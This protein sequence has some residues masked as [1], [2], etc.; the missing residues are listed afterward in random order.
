[1]ES[2]KSSMPA[3]DYGTLLKEYEEFAYVISHDLSGPLRQIAGFT[4]ILLK[5][6]GELPEKQKIYRDMIDHAVREAQLS[7]DALLEFSRLNTDEKNFE[8]FGYQRIICRHPEKAASGDCRQRRRY[9]IKRPA[10]NPARRQKNTDT[11][12]LPP[13]A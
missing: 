11:G 5:E 4:D 9:Q 7:L 13:S 10:F 6:M 12:F 2:S 1:M 3:N 8:E